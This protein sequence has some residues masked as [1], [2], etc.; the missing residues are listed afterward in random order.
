VRE[1]K[2][3]LFTSYIIGGLLVLLPFHA[4]LSTWLGSNVGHLDLVRIWKEILI[5]VLAVPALWLFFK[6]P[7]LRTWGRRSFLAQLIALYFLI[8]FALGI[9]GLKHNQLNS[10]ALIYALIINLRFLGFFLVCLS[11]SAYSDWLY[12]YWLRLLL[13]P[14]AL[15]IGFGLLQK[16]VL[17]YD[18]LK[19]FGYS[20]KTIPAYQTVDSDLNFRRIQSTLRGANPLGAYLVL[21]IPALTFVRNRAWRVIGLV[22]GFVVLYFS[23]SR[24]AWIGL[25]AALALLGLWHFGGSK[26]SKEILAIVAVLFLV[27]CTGV[28]ALRG[29]HNAQDALFHTS[30]ASA[31]VSSNA[32]RATAIKDAAYDVLHNPL[33]RG[34]GTAGPASFR[35]TGH[36]ARIA[37][38]YYLQIAQETGVLG[39]IIFLI[40]NG[41][42][43]WQLWLSRQDNLAKV[44][45]VS[46]AG[47]TLVNL[48]SHA[49]TD[50]T[51]SLIWW[52]LAGVALAALPKRGVKNW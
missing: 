32:Q 30:S 18:F 42:V 48:V 17:P 16:F 43:G 37:E 10:T 6:S 9:W 14:A 33:G 45:L 13:L 35:N 11:V 28:Y 29:N 4:V 20:P 50:D 23:Y 39:M 25:L 21:I 15:V 3:A 49:W 52:G 12:K 26:K 2:T 8:H 51:L 7:A 41:M 47:I 22:G 40:I 5:T 38:N 36:P 24:S 19:H 27:A 46:L 1:H 31:N 34:P 44:L